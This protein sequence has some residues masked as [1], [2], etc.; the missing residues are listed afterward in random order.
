MFQ[1]AMRVAKE[2]EAMDQA[3]LQAQKSGKESDK[4]SD[5]K[6]N[7]DANGQPPDPA[8]PQ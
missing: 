3:A 7:R 6:S 2:R 1:H 8:A 4:E 5:K